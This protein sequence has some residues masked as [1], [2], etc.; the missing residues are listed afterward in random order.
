MFDKYSKYRIIKYN[1]ILQKKLDINFENSIINYQFNFQTA[2]EILI[3]LSESD[4][5]FDKYKKY[6]SELSS[7][8]LFCFKYSYHFPENLDLKDNN[9]KNIFLTKYRGFKLMIIFFHQILI[10]LILKIEL[11]Y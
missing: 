6:L 9:S 8:A 4:E 1:K 3:K 7:E 10:Q 11:I 5:Q 2:E